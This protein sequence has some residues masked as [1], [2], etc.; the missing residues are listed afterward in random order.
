[1]IL[2]MFTQMDVSVGPR[3]QIRH[4]SYRCEFFIFWLLHQHVWVLAV[5]RIALGALEAGDSGTCHFG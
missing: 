5:Q 1:M 3:L 2:C 4:T